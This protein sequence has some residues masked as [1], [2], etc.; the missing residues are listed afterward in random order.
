MDA[1]DVDGKFFTKDMVTRSK[2]EASFWYDFKFVN[3]AI[4]KVQPKDTYC[5]RLNETAVCV[6]VHRL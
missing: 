3:P 2:T 5:E 1:Q 6:G 4:K